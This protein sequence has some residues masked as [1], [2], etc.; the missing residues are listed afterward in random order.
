MKVLIIIPAYNESENI[1]RVVSNLIENYPQYDYVIINDGSNDDTSDICRRNEYN[2]IDLPVNI[3][4]SGGF[5][6]GMKYALRNG[7]DYAI[8][9]DG[10]GQHN[11]EYIAK[12]LDEIHNNDL[13]F[14]IGSRFIGERKPKSLRMLGGNLISV[15]L[16]TTTGKTF[17]DPTS[18]MRMYN[19]KLISLL[20]NSIDFGPEPDTLAHLV[21]SGAKYSEVQVSMND[22]LAGESYLSMTRSIKYMAHILS[23]ITLIQWFRKKPKI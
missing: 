11:P 6:T 10:D 14:V 1:E 2:L 7:Y 5:Q 18:G 4:L 22:R 21:R 8:Q 16:K 13:D 17:K 20:S 23:S 19:K 15:I 9:F 12:M 3:G